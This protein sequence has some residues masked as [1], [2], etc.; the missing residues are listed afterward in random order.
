MQAW[1]LKTECVWEQTHL[2][3]MVM[4]T[5][6][7]VYE[8]FKI[9]MRQWISEV[10]THASSWTLIIFRLLSPTNNDELFL[11]VGSLSEPKRGIRLSPHHCWGYDDVA[12][13]EVS[14]MCWCHT[15][16]WEEIWHAKGKRNILLFWVRTALPVAS[17]E[18]IK[19][20]GWRR[21]RKGSRVQ[22]P[23]PT[24]PLLSVYYDFTS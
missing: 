13:V 15:L 10:M 17:Y 24:L 18:S 6:K 20:G 7:A 2:F 9:Y 14:D 21:A 4:F 23:L 5:W 22:C 1:L 12:S 11:S 19:V 16:V 8:N 3:M